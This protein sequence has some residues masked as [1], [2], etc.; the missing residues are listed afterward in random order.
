MQNEAVF[1]VLYRYSKYAFQIVYRY[2]EQGDASYTSVN[3]LQSMYFL[4]GDGTFLFGDG[5]YTN[6]DDSYYL[7]TDAGFMRFLLMYGVFVSF[8]AYLGFS[9]VIYSY[10]REIYKNDND[11]FSISC[12]VLVLAFIYHYKGELIMYNVGFMKC[13]YFFFTST[14]LKSINIKNENA[15]ISNC[16]YSNT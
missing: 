9:F 3:H 10:Y 14:L 4:T 13:V 1:D 8:F 5:K 11:L 15:K 6:V 7:H 16:I 2:L 12:G